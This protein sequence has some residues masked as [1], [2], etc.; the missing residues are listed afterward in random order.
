[1]RLEDLFS[2]HSSN[3]SF[4]F[5]D[6]N[7]YLGKNGCS[8]EERQIIAKG[9]LQQFFF[10][11]DS[12][13]VTYPEW[14]SIGNNPIKFPMHY[15]SYLTEIYFDL[16]K[17]D[18]VRAYKSLQD[19]S[20]RWS[21]NRVYLLLLQIRKIFEENREDTM[22]N[23]PCGTMQE[24]VNLFLKGITQNADYRIATVQDKLTYLDFCINAIKADILG[25]SLTP[26]LYNQLPP[27]DYELFPIPFMKANGDKVISFN[28][29][30]VISLPYDK[31]RMFNAVI[32][33][34]T[35][36]LEDITNNIKGDYFPELNLIVVTNGYHH[37]A[38]ASLAGVG[39]CK[40]T[41]YRLADNFNTLKLTDN[42]WVYGDRA[43]RIIDNRAAIL[44]S[45]A[46]E[47]YKLTQI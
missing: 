23:I 33:I 22:I 25:N 17:G 39:N 38:A 24:E 1:M 46:Y 5:R 12:C 30:T 6:R 2:W 7:N 35:S 3:Y 16:Q 18:Y 14:G 29:N 26:V 44:Y 15:I 9:F 10:T 27:D 47:K 37:S 45:L 4:F 20:G 31:E 13:T 41:E 34:A 40:V 8:Q 28:G 43:R 32:N 21:N 19:F 36:G 42:Y 11:L